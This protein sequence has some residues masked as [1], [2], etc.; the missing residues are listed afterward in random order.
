MGFICWNSFDDW[1]FLVFFHLFNQSGEQQGKKNKLT[2]ENKYFDFE[3]FAKNNGYYYVL[4][5]SINLKDKLDLFREK[6]SYR[7]W[8]IVKNILYI[9]K[10][11]NVYIFNAISRFITGH[12]STQYRE[13]EETV[14]LFESYRERKDVLFIKSY[15][16][17]LE[18]Q[19]ASK[20]LL[21]F[22]NSF[23]KPFFKFINFVEHREKYEKYEYKGNEKFFETHR[24]FYDGEEYKVRNFVNLEL[25][26]IIDKLENDFGLSVEVE[27]RNK[28]IVIYT[29]DE[30]KASGLIRRS[31]FLNENEL[32]KFIGEC[33][34]ICNLLRDF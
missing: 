17:Y 27:V 29:S 7:R 9:V 21:S 11:E 23:F 12:N 26:N 28:F 5:D 34:K 16:C 25:M 14:Y 15:K 18:V 22:I 20:K 32:L 1:F 19:G 4:E 2:Y 31:G 10:T 8:R 13:T 24:V 6:V 30:S 3:N 33:N